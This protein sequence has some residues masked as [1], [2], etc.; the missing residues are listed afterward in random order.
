MTK[1][2]LE[3]FDPVFLC[4]LLMIFNQSKGPFISEYN[5]LLLV[6]VRKD[7]DVFFIFYVNLFHF[8]DLCDHRLHP[9]RHPDLQ[10][11]L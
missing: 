8:S 1:S 2:E 7:F 5:L 6:A 11:Y 4:S 3:I 9:S 10:G